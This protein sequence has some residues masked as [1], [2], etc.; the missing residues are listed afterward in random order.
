MIGNNVNDKLEISNTEL[1]QGAGTFAI[2]AMQYLI[3]LDTLEDKKVAS[4]VISPVKTGLINLSKVWSDELASEVRENL[5]LLEEASQNPD[6]E[7]YHSSMDQWYAYGSSALDQL[8]LKNDMLVAANNEVMKIYDGWSGIR[9]KSEDGLSLIGEIG[10]TKAN[11]I[12]SSFNNALNSQIRTIKDLSEEANA[13]TMAKNIDADK[14]MEGLQIKLD[15]FNTGINTEIATGLGFQEGEIGDDYTSYFLPKDGRVSTT[16]YDELKGIY[17]TAVDNLKG[18]A[19]SQLDALSVENP[20]MMKAIF[21]AVSDKERTDSAYEKIAA[22]IPGV[23]AKNKEEAVSNLKSWVNIV[24]QFG[25]HDK[26]GDW[27]KDAKKELTAGDSELV[28]IEGDIL[29]SQI[30]DIRDALGGPALQ[31]LKSKTFGGSFDASIG[32]KIEAVP[33]I[34]DLDGLIIS[35]TGNN[36]ARDHLLSE[37][38][39]E[40][41]EFAEIH[42]ANTKADISTLAETDLQTFGIADSLVNENISIDSLRANTLLDPKQI[43]LANKFAQNVITNPTLREEWDKVVK[44]TNLELDEAAAYQARWATIPGMPAPTQQQLET[45]QIALKNQV[46]VWNTRLND[47]MSK[48]DRISMGLRSFQVPGTLKEFQPLLSDCMH[49]DI[50]YNAQQLFG[51]EDNWSDRKDYPTLYAFQSANTQ[52][53]KIQTLK[54][55]SALYTKGSSKRGFTYDENLLKDPYFADSFVDMF[56]H[57]SEARLFLDLM[58]LYRT[59]ESFDPFISTI[60]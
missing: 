21:S 10:E 49:Q 18:L 24:D 3:K 54:A 59:L 1:L 20:Y 34:S 11:V 23:T 12:T 46:K 58:V 38:E 51:S 25:L 43:E 4:S 5:D 32:A 44:K 41:T 31:Y 28:K 39:T 33:G 55:V 42:T 7:L 16:R 37:F 52:A 53:D 6:Y 9:N 48:T 47:A 27:L 22:T 17:D 26:L 13:L 40:K 8:S 2:D 19:T 29:E 15:E 30:N 50:L 60:R 36:Q 56:P 57:E 14:E 35:I 45:K